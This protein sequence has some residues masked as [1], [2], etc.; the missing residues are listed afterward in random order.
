M[1]PMPQWQQPVPP[2]KKSSN[3]WIILLVV[4]LLLVVFGIPVIFGFVYFLTR[5]SRA[6]RRSTVWAASTTV[7]STLTESS[8]TTNGLIT[9][10][11]PAT[12][13]VKVLDDSTLVAAQSFGGGEDEIVTFGA[14]AT[15]KTHDPHELGRLL[16]DSVAKSISEKGGTFTKN[17]ETPG[18]CLGKYAGVEV[19]ATWVLPP[20][21]PYI[22]KSCF[23]VNAGHGY[24]IRYDVPKWRAAKEVPELESIEMATEL[25]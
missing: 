5:A 9:I 16:L 21:A 10:H 23:F 7:S 19:E 8:S 6:S 13:H 12:F 1:Q 17:S 22:S 11:Y 14:V 3:T 4:G 15:P 24:E 20:V 18:T 25:H 2:P